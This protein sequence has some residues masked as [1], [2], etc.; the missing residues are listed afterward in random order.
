MDRNTR[1]RWIRFS[2]RPGTTQTCWMCELTMSRTLYFRGPVVWINSCSSWLL[3]SHTTPFSISTLES[4]SSS[5]SLRKIWPV[6]WFFMAAARNKN[7]VLKS[8]ELGEIFM[9]S[10]L[11]PLTQDV[12]SPLKL[13]DQQVSGSFRNLQDLQE[14]CN[15]NERV[16]KKQQHSHPVPWNMW[17]GV[18]H[19]FFLGAS[20]EVSFDD[21]TPGV[22]SSTDSTSIVLLV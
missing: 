14:T 22:I 7:K 21:L 15:N 6:S 16:R 9:E 13:L 18:F 8:V 17:A 5:S 11:Y 1:R 20:G 19:T 4:G 10:H 3:Y 2:F 12:R